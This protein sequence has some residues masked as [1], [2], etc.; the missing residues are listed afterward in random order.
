M[1]GLTWARQQQQ[2]SSLKSL[3]LEADQRKLGIQIPLAPFS[4]GGFSGIRC[5]IPHMSVTTPLKGEVR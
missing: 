2:T 3:S 4:N 5:P 1:V